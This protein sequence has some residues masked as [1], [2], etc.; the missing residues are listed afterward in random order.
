[1]ADIVRPAAPLD[2]ALRPPARLRPRAGRIDQFE[3]QRARHRIGL[4][5]PQLK[6][7]D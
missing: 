6:P 1:M 3:A 4:G 7:L 2:H 5:Q